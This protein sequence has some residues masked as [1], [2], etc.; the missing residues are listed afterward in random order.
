M[1]CQ[2]FISLLDIL[3][4]VNYLFTLMLL[5]PLEF[6]AVLLSRVKSG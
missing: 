3:K 6:R 1:S 2:L 4:I 5:C